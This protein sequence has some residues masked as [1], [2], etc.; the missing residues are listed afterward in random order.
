M[1]K[2]IIFIKKWSNCMFHPYG[3]VA[4]RLTVKGGL[5]QKGYCSENSLRSYETSS[6]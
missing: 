3:P 4:V 2:T 6:L 1:L 5:R